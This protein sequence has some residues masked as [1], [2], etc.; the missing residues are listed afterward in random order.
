MN[1]GRKEPSPLCSPINTTLKD[2]LIS[3]AQ[4]SLF[5]RLLVLIL[6][7]QSELTY[8]GGFKCS[9]LLNSLLKMSRETILKHPVAFLL[10]LR[11]SLFF[12]IRIQSSRLSRKKTQRLHRDQPVCLSPFLA[13]EA[14]Q[15]KSA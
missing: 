3:S 13:P 1:P 4:L 14:S 6:A 11:A 7:F 10:A 5:N 12:Q 9:K 8:F 15:M 2:V